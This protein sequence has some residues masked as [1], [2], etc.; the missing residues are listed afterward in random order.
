MKEEIMNPR[1][2]SSSCVILGGTG[3][4][5]R[6]LH[7]HLL[8]EGYQVAAF[9]RNAFKDTETLCELIDG[10]DVLIMLAG[11][12]IGQ[13]WTAKHKQAIWDSRLK[14]N[15]LLVEALGKVDKRPDRILSASAIGIYPQK[16]CA[17]PVDETCAEVDESE[18]GQLGAAWEEVSLKLQPTPTLMRF[19][20]VLG[21]EGGALQKMLPAFKL[22]L[23]GPVA[24]GQQCMSWIH[25]H[26][27]CRAVSF[28][29]KKPQTS[30]VYNL[31]SP[32]PI[33]N[34][35]F[36]HTLAKVLHRPFW[37]PLP[38]WQLRL[39]FGEGAQVLTHS[40]AV[41]P[42]RLI[43]EGFVFDYANIK[44]ALENLLLSSS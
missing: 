25:I 7:Q 24:G 33:S 32:E 27:L 20:V 29:L 5:G 18:L 30:G 19:G 3:F 34:K 37:L 43:D 16:A 1:Q 36:G 22:G 8:E 12:N 21:K 14:T 42:K 10:V 9:G 6:A 17:Q 11:E 15:Q 41:F 26:D 4:V 31:C 28:I 35:V 39:M 44:D 2:A 13:R 40:S 23:G 38:S